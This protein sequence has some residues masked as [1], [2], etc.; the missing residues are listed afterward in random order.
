MDIIE[1]P[2]G[3]RLVAGTVQRHRRLLDI[4]EDTGDHDSTE[5]PG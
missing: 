3:E 4:Y 2:L 1:A 5:D